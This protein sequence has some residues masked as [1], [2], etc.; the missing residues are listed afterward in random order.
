MCGPTQP[1]GCQLM[2]DG[3]VV[4]IDGWGD[5]LAE[6]IPGIHLYWRRHDDVF[7]RRKGQRKGIV[8][9]LV[10][11][12][13]R[14]GRVRQRDRGIKWRNLTLTGVCGSW[15]T[16]IQEYSTSAAEAGLSVAE[17]IIGKAQ[18]RRKIIV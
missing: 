2:L 8:D 18:P 4:V 5:E 16:R 3:Q 10:G 6:G 9:P 15:N 17:H 13:E 12:A 7:G 11:V 14:P 1:I